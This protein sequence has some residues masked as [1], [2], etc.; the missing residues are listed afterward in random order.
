MQKLTRAFL[1]GWL[2]LGLAAPE[3][4]PAQAA[5]G[6]FAPT[7]T[8][9]V[10][11]VTC[12]LSDAITAANTDTATG[13]CTAGSGV[14]TLN[15]TADVVLTAVD[16]TTY[17]DTGLPIITSGMIIEGNG[18]TISRQ[19]GAPNFRILVAS[20]AGARVT[21]N[22]LTLT[23]GATPASGAGY[24]RY[25]GGVLVYNGALMSVS[26]CDISYN[27]AM[28]G[29]G[30]AAVIGSSL[31]VS[32]NT[33]VHH[34]TVGIGGSGGGLR[35]DSG[36]TLSV[37][38]ST[39]RNNTGG[40]G[41]GIGATSNANVTVTR[42]TLR[43]NSSS[44]GGGLYV[45]YAKATVTDSTIYSNTASLYDG[46]GIQITGDTSQ[47]TVNRSVIS[48]NKVTGA[49]LNGGGIAVSGA[50][51]IVTDSTLD[52]NST[53]SHGGG[54]YASVPVTMTGSTVSNNTAANKGG[55]GYLIGASGQMTAT[56]STVD[57]NTA[58]EGGGFYLDA[59]PTVRL[60]Y[61]TL[62]GNSATSSGG[63]VYVFGAESTLIAQS[64]I[65]ALQT[66]G[67]DCVNYNN[68]ATLT[69]QG[70]NIESATSCG[71]GGGGDQQNVTAAALKLKPLADTGGATLTRALGSDSVALEQIPAGTNDCGGDIGGD[72]RGIARPQDWGD[73]ET[74]DHCDVGAWE[75][76]PNPP[77]A[78]TGLAVS[79]SGRG[80]TWA[81]LLTLAAGL[82][83]MKQRRLA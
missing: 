48:A 44:G 13:G 58:N 2:V 12:T 66:L 25:G 42:S 45:A 20:G 36:S 23:G 26:G 14:D 64:S 57:G 56:N 60:R 18:H 67:A 76:R 83:V 37:A 61:S 5:Q 11:E 77:N 71:F 62:S 70:Y 19:S 54:L 80:A 79:V 31:L 38:D 46:G 33:V 65:I 81:L 47:V 78:V 82:L 3:I 34:N 16:N 17:G 15:L 4:T 52:S 10:D 39:I 1:L 55:G 29:G 68:W 43:D 73:D 41:G 27:S 9:D 7:A 6:V 59:G 49:G 28:W 63:G 21:L 40:Q 8:I 75:G 51:L 53:E 74:P 69:S 22:D 35:A 24:I 30:M 32:N 50:P 72:Q